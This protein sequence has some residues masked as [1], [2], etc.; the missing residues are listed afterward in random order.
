MSAHKPARVLGPQFAPAW[1][2]PQFRYID[3]V[4]GA[5]AGAITDPAGDEDLGFPE[6]TPLDQMT[7]EQREAYWKNQ[8]KVQQKKFEDAQ[9]REDAYK[10]FG[11]P[12][13]LQSAV[14]A[15]EQARVAALGDNDRALEEARNA[16]RAE[17]ST[18]HLAAGV[19]GMLIAL[20]KSAD[21]DFEAASSRVDGAI[22]FADLTRFV[23]ENGTL[24]AAKVQKF[25]QSIGS[26]GGNDPGSQQ[27]P[28]GAA[29]QRA[30]EGRIP[31]APGAS[32]SV[33]AAQQAARERL[34]KNKP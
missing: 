19:K 11:T 30:H 20:T 16:G 21:E 13:E 9:K 7:G 12:A 29:Y 1:H 10:K 34:T 2:R 26:A 24:D 5:E 32:G 33:A 25:A 17:G 6:G 23:G 15:A 22:E 14:D 3:S 18:V 8:S 31:P 27:Q 4:P 28:W